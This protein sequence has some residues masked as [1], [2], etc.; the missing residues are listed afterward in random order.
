MLAGNTVQTDPQLP[1]DEG[2]GG[3]PASGPPIT[4]C[5]FGKGNILLGGGGSDLIEGRGADDVIDGDAWLNVQLQAPDVSTPEAGDTKLVASMTA[6]RDDVFAGRINPGDI[7]IARKIETATPVAGAQPALDT[8]VFSGPRADYT[9]AFANGKVVVTDNN[10]ADIDDGTD[11]LSNVERLRFT[12]Q[13]VNLAPV[14]ALNPTTRAFGSRTVGSPSP[15]QTVTLSNTGNIPLS[16]ASITRAGA[17]PGDYQITSNACGATLAAGA[18]CVVAVRFNPTATGLA[19]RPSGSCTTPAT[20][21]APSARRRSP[22][23]ARSPTWRPRERPRST[24]R[25]RSWDS[26]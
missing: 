23:P 24:T 20:C 15:S 11:T 2:E 22:A 9:I 8:A 7:K 25:R 5:G 4:V 16:I 10:V 17:N 3:P 18:N 1:G 13:T 6:L 26:C 12:D 21:R 14:A 19:P